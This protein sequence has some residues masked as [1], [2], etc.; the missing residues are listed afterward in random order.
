MNLLVCIV[1]LMRKGFL[2]GDHQVHECNRRN[3]LLRPFQLS[4]TLSILEDRKTAFFAYLEG[5]GFFQ[6]LGF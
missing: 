3:L 4:S 1:V 6:G 5:F 2:S